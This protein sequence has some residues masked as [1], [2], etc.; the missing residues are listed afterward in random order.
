[1]NFALELFLTTLG[2]IYFI[3]IVAEVIYKLQTHFGGD[4]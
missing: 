1:M 3:V 4:D 2:M